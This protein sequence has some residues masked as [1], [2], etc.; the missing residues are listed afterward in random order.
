MTRATK[1]STAKPAAGSGG[2]P[3]SGSH[4]VT[5]D[6][7]DLKLSN[8][9]KVLYPDAGF[10]KADVIAWLVRIAPVV[11]PHLAERPLTLKRYP[12]GVEEQFFYEKN[13]PKHRP[14]W[15]RTT[16]VWSEGNQ[17]EMRYCVVEDVAT[18]AW[19][20]NLA[21]LELHA[22]LATADDLARPNVLAFDLD[23]GAPATI[24]E[25]CRVALLLRDVFDA[26]GLQAFPK[27]SGSKGMQVY[28]PLNTP[29][30]TFEDTKAVAHGLARLLERQHPDLVVSK[31]LKSLR[32]GKVLVDWSQNDEHKTT[33]C[34]YSLRARSQP[35]V[36]T[37]I[38]WDEVEAALE[39]GDPEQLVFTTSD[40][41]D[42]VE[43]M[44]DLFAPVLELEQSL[45]Q[46]G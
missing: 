12:N 8:L 36:S 29:G 32:P 31:M 6:G 11:L 46:L 37:P 15:V 42:R 39:S 20:G 38:T 41:L 10:T 16:T 7:H 34:P 14:D 22:S 9:D 44:G 33:V 35:T 17:K 23:P 4:V 21:D 24:V 28:L 30:I 40:V 3:R 2:M 5:I 1:A 26:W 18:L 45:P 27:T 13:C 43:R 25:C 19:L